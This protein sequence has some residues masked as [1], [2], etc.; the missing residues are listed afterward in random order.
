MRWSAPGSTGRIAVTPP[1]L[2][3]DQLRALLDR[4]PTR[5]PRVALGLDRGDSVVVLGAHPDD[6]TFGL[7]ATIS[8]LGA[9][10]VDV[11]LVSLSVERPRSTSSTCTSPDSPSAAARGHGTTRHASCQDREG[12]CEE[13]CGAPSR[14]TQKTK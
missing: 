5:S 6:E 11:H 14:R 12:R 3:A 13:S 1:S 7:G 4:V 10:G 2:Y 9:D 8:E